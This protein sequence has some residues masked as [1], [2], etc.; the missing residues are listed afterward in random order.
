VNQGL[1]HGR[2]FFMEIAE[3]GIALYEAD[4]RELAKPK[5]K[6]PSEAATT[7]QDYFDEYFPDAMSNFEL[8]KVAIERDFKKQAAFLLHR[9][10]EALYQ[11]ILLTLTFYTPYDHNIA[12]LRLQAEGRNPALFD[13]WP[14][15][16]R[17]ERA[18]FQKLKDAYVKARYSKHYQIDLEEL[19][20]LAERVEIL[21]RMTHSICTAHVA[22]LREKA[23]H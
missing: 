15:G 16:L 6:T 13:V 4:D 18:M 8:A 23:A 12:F 2:V 14:R 19:N 1:S 11:A 9:T 17:K 7:A 20:W 22:K 21:G 3:Q 10:A 5:P